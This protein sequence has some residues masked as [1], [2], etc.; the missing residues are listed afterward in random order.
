M[1]CNRHYVR[2]CIHCWFDKS[3][4]LPP[5]QKRIIY[6]DQFVISNMMKALDPTGKNVDGF[7]RTLFEKLDRLSKLQ[8]IVCPDSPI[9]DYES[10]VDGRYEKFRTVFRQLSHGISFHDPTTILHAQ[11]MRAFRCWEAGKPCEADV[12]RKFALTQEPDVW[13]DVYRIEL[14]FTTPGLAQ[15][16]NTRRELVIE[17]LHKKCREWQDDANFSFEQIFND[18]LAGHA[19]VILEQ[20]SRHLAHYAA[21]RA[22]YA[23]VDDE[24]C[25]PPPGERVVSGML[26]ELSSSISS[27]EERFAAIREFFAS[28]HFR[29]VPGVRITGLFWAT[30]ARDI[31]NGRKSDHFPKS[32]MFNDIDAVAMY[33]PFCDAMFVDKEIAHLTKQGPLREELGGDVRFFSLRGTEKAEFLDYLDGIERSASAEHLQLVEEVYGQDGP[34]PYVDLLREE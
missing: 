12:T 3:V 18:E 8:L 23:P 29:R 26:R 22:G 5:V 25:F 21:V 19:K 34:T 32:G 13:Q 14:N 9:Q 1:I 16:L 4:T 6:L 24:L 27:Y 2:R 20:Y 7:Y 17:R 11:I 33:S 10:V 31:H 28:E 30:I 15:E